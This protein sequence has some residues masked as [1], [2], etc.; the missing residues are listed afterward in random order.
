MQKF[1]T[2]V[3]HIR[4]GMANRVYSLLFPLYQHF[5]TL[6]FEAANPSSTMGTVISRRHLERIDAMVNRASST[7][8]ILTGGK[9]M[10][11]DISEVDGFDFSQG[12]FYPP[13][14]VAD[15]RVEDEIW[16][17]EVFGPVVVVKSFKVSVLH[18]CN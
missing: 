18:D 1:L 16:Q 13:T 17:E 11:D 14:V 6:S 8:K 2:K 15:V 5:P 9:P 7:A 10:T 4:K 3:E 12:S